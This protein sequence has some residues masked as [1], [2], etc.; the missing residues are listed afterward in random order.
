MIGFGYIGLVLVKSLGVDIGI[1]VFLT[2]DRFGP[3]Q[4]ENIR[5]GLCQRDC[6]DRLELSGGNSGSY[7]PK[8][9]ARGIG[10]DFYR[11]STGQLFHAVMKIAEP[12][13]PWDSMES[14]SA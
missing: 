14:N 12:Y 7:D 1:G 4:L 6:P 3:Q 5:G 11:S 9:Q 13:S 2:I 10:R 8:S